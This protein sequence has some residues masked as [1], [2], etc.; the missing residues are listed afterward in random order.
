MFKYSKQML[1]VISV[2]LVISLLATLFAGCDRS[3]G[4]S[5]VASSQITSSAESSEDPDGPLTPYEETVIITKPGYTSDAVKYIEGESIDDNVMTRF[6]EDKLNLKF[7]NKWVVDLTGAAEKLAL[8]ISSN[9]L[10]DVFTVDKETL[11]RLYDNEQIADMT[12]LI[13]QYK[14]PVLDQILSVQDGDNFTPATFNG[15]TYGI[16]LITGFLDYVA[17]VYIRSD[18]ME[19]YDLEAPETMQD[20]ID[21]AQTFVDNDASGMG[22]TIGIAMD[23]AYNF[24]CGGGTMKLF[25]NSLKAYPGAWVKD[26]TNKLVCGDIQP[27]MKQA[28][29]MM[30]NA[31]ASGLFDTEFAVKDYSK[32]VETI[33]SGQCG[34]AP[35]PFYFPIWPLNQLAGVSETTDW[36]PYS[37]PVDTDGNISTQIPLAASTWVVVRKDY[38][39][40][41]AA[42]KAM[43]LWSEILDGEHTE[44]YYETT[45]SEKYAEVGSIMNNYALPAFF[46]YPG[47][48]TKQGQHLEEARETGDTSSLTPYE[49]SQYDILIAGGLGAWGVQRALIDVGKV[50]ESYKYVTSEFLGA[51]T[52][53]MLTKNVALNKLINDTYTKIIMGQDIETFDEFVEQWYEEGGEEITAEV[54]EWYQ[55]TLG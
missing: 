24:F 9:D 5:S 29:K 4:V 1:Y 41:E 6:Y 49:K 30:Q 17:I 27:E 55:S 16:P 43:S 53:T 40:P 33:T 14:A 34:I 12:D 8:A 50:L 32:M 21:I 7:E 36:T 44:W 31:Y 20:I 13:D 52:E 45:A 51:P 11:K 22:K 39:H 15:R 25:A 54:N 18:W 48:V 3:P 37:F 10:P 26:S 2:M 19:R 42:L 38:E 46:T 35:G 47:E 28:L 23:S